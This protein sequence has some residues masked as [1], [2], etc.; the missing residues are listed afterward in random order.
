MIVDIGLALTFLSFA[1]GLWAFVLQWGV[2][3]IR[4][5]MSETRDATVKTGIALEAHILATERRLT[6]L[7]TEFGFVRRY[8][9]RDD[10]NKYD[11]R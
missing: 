8:L 1:F 2:R 4:K 9:T 11:T 10:E 6:M 5:E 3:V 7:E